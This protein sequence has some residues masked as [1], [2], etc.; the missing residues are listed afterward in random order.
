MYH[1]FSEPTIFYKYRQ[2]IIVN[3]FLEFCICF[4]KIIEH[5]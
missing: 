1:D 5:N 2:L 3:I 4:E